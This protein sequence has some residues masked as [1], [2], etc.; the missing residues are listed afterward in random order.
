MLISRT[1]AEA[2]YE[3]RVQRSV[4]ELER[5]ICDEPLRILAFLRA[6]PQRR[7]RGAAVE[8]QL[9]QRVLERALPQRAPRRRG[10]RHARE[11]CERREDPPADPRA[12]DRDDPAFFRRQRVAV[13]GADE[14]VHATAAVRLELD[15]ADGAPVHVA[16]EQQDRGG[17]PGGL[18]TAR[19]RP[20]PVA[21]LL[22]GSVERRP[23]L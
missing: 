14:L 8:K 15:L 5:L 11:P 22:E 20:Q 23:V 17:R 1:T 2:S 6:S 12:G 19:K 21:Q 3:V 16:A 9:A 4:R 13:R 10:C 7:G 18:G